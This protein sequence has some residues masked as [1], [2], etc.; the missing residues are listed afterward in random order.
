[1]KSKEKSKNYSPNHGIRVDDRDYRIIAK[2]LKR[3]NRSW[4]WL[5][6]TIA[7]QIRQSQ[8]INVNLLLM[9]AKRKSE[10]RSVSLWESDKEYK[11]IDQ[12]FDFQKENEKP[13]KEK[14]WF[15]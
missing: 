12:T 8:S 3:A 11:P 14:W 7:N 1:M 13:N 10:S 2:F 6:K 4:S 9:E 15:K 5:F